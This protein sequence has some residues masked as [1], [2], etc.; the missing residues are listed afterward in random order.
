M[1]TY[2][3]RLITTINITAGSDQV[4]KYL[5]QIHL[6][7][8]RTQISQSPEIVVAT[9]ASVL[10]HVNSSKLSLKSVQSL[11]IDE[12]DLVL[13]YG[14]D[15]DLQQI[16]SLLPKTVQ[17]YIMSATLTD[18]IHTLKTA[19]C[20]NP[21]ILKLEEAERDTDTLTQYY[22][23]CAEDD[24]FLL[25]YVI[26]K[27]KLLRGKSIIFVNDIDRCYRVKLFLEQF[28]IRSCV[29]NAEL[30]LNSRYCLFSSCE[31]MEESILWKNL[32]RVSMISSWQQT[33]QT[34]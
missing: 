26:L 2:C 1:I 28:G 7:N 31:L 25:L 10:H 23:E 9:P 27:L 17:T 12:A 24:K 13:S 34:P 16:S 32:I 18:D 6:I 14:Y 29:L 11:V 21:A 30:P 19:M 15:S 5:P 4:Q 22:V 3:E 8:I 33:K 20:R